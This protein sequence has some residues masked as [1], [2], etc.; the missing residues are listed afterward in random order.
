[1]GLVYVPNQPVG[2]GATSGNLKNFNPRLAGTYSRVGTI[3]QGVYTGYRFVR[4]NYKLFTGI[5]AV[6]TGA[7]VSLIDKGGVSLNHEAD[8]NFRKTYR[9]KKFRSSARANKRRFQ[10][11]FRCGCSQHVKRSSNRCCC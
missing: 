11:S 9:T 7:G 4:A 3:I 8:N 10:H 2:K 1:M 5:G 6:S